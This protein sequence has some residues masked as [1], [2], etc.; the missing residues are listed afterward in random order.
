MFL[1]PHGESRRCEFPL[2][3]H[4]T[5]SFTILLTFSPKDFR[6]TALDMLDYLT[7]TPSNRQI[8]LAGMC[9]MD[10]DPSLCSGVM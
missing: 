2:Q 4:Y 5:L 8:E 1:L 3:H 7:P 6:E 9:H 10:P